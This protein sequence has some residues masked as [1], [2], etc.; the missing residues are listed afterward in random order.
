VREF[1]MA[2][3]DLHEGSMTLKV[4]VGAAAAEKWVCE[5]NARSHK[6]MIGRLKALSKAH[7]QMPILFGYEAC[8]LVGCHLLYYALK[9]SV[10]DV[11]VSIRASG[12]RTYRDGGRHEQEIRGPA[13]GRGARAVE[14]LGEQG[15]GGRIQDQ[16]R[17]YLVDGRR[18][19]PGLDRPMHCRG[20]LSPW[21]DRGQRS[22]AVR[23]ARAGGGAESQ[24]ATGTAAGE[25]SRW[26]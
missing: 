20:V 14:K 24:E 13:I 19:W 22:R 4:A 6:K 17:Q 25:D 1:I 5:N 9:F 2:G 10:E 26:R 7:R 3:C 11:D 16:A 23:A 12:Y 21:Q 15:E 8:G 18:G